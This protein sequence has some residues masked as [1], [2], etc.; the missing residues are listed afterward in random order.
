MSLSLSVG[1]EDLLNKYQG[2]PLA[3]AE[4]M[5]LGTL[6]PFEYKHAPEIVSSIILET[7]RIRLKALGKLNGRNIKPALDDDPDFTGHID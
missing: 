4:A 2:S 3:V 6:E 1:G 5:I 7:A